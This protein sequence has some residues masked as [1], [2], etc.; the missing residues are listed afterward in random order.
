MA[1]EDKARKI[2]AD[3]LPAS[4]GAI[5]RT[6]L[7]PGGLPPEYTLQDARNL[8]LTDYLKGAE[9]ATGRQ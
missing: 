3:S 8:Y 4:E 7:D 1:D 6:V 9:G 5:I 2:L